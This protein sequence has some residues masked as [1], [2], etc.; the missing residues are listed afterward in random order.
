MRE[1]KPVIIGYLTAQDPKN[2]K[3]W[4]GIHNFMSQELELRF[5]NVIF[6]GPVKPTKWI[7]NIL[8]LFSKF[9]LLF[10]RKK[11]NRQHNNFLSRYYAKEFGKK[12]TNKK[13]DILIAPAA[14]SEIA[15]LNTKIPIIYISDTSYNQIKDYY[16][17]YSNFSKLSNAVAEKIE[18]AAINKATTLIYSSKWAAE[19]VINNY[20]IVNKEIF[21]IQFGA[22]IIEVPLKHKIIKSFSGSLN[23]LFLGKQWERK[24]GPIVLETVRMLNSN[25]FKVNLTI[26]G[27]DPPEEISEPYITVYS[28]LDKNLVKEYNAFLQLMYESHLLFLPTKADCTP[29]VFC[30]AAAFGLPVLSR[31]TG[32]VSSIIKTGINGVLLPENAKV[33]DYYNTLVNLIENP[34]HLIS[35]SEKARHFYEI[36]FNWTVWGDKIEEIIIKMTN[37]N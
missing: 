9:H 30:E 37:F 17:S 25:G 22:N 7:R 20:K 18:Q 10:F 19:H 28:F 34:N 14:S 16:D 33:K 8:G 36:K 11:F 35:M 4:S 21:V 5:N 3:S 13:I 12:I 26:C 27:C 24:G 29:I 15:F 2:K 1:K 23:L 32:G 31:D 6:L